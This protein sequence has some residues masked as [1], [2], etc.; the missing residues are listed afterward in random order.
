MQNSFPKV[1]DYA[2]ESV[3]G[4][5]SFAVVYRA[6]HLLTNEWVAIKVISKDTD[7][8]TLFD[9]IQSEIDI[10]YSADHPLIVHLYDC[11]EDQDNIYLVMELIEGESLLDHVNRS[12]GL[13]EDRARVLFHQLIS[14]I[15]YMHNEM[16]IVHRDLK[17]E[18]LLLDRNGNL[19]IIDFGLS[20]RQ[21]NSSA[22][23][24]TVCGSPAYVA[25][26]LITG[27]P[28]TNAVDI[29]S[30]GVILYAMCAGVLPFSDSNVTRQIQKVILSQPDYPASM[31]PS[32]SSLL[33]KLLEK[34]PAARITIDE[35]KYSPWFCFNDKC[36]IDYYAKELRLREFPMPAKVRSQM[37][38]LGFDPDAVSEDRMD[39]LESSTDITSYRIIRGN[40]ITEAIFEMQLKHSLVSLR[41]TDSLPCSV[42][43]KLHMKDHPASHSAP[44]HVRAMDEKK[45]LGNG[46][47]K[48]KGVTV[49]TILPQ[50]P[51]RRPSK[52]LPVFPTITVPNVSIRSRRPRAVS[53]VLMA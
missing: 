50:L 19:R 52:A 48:R 18:N 43:L 32:L 31:S 47:T 3:M 45:K 24:Y 23:Y 44:P 42:A 8:E 37:E 29:W 6:R 15:D 11:F 7:D 20:K 21:S 2:I 26:E 27:N 40:A 49:S 12:G 53:S 41:T 35:I 22:C 14:A 30:A 9:Q 28:Y 33:K 25:P 39:V 10:G 16:R 38:D 13:T 17:A 1:V 34:D 51:A 46:F 4:R 5:G 36:E